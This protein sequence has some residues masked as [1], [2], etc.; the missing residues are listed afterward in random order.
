MGWIVWQIQN[1]S[2]PTGENF[3]GMTFSGGTAFAPS[4]RAAT[5]VGKLSKTYAAFSGAAGDT[6]LTLTGG[7][8][9]API[10]GVYAPAIGLTTNDI[11][12]GNCFFGFSGMSGSAVPGSGNGTY[13]S[14]A[15]DWTMYFGT[16]VPNPPPT[17]PSGT[18]VNP[19]A[20]NNP[21]KIVGI[22]QFQALTFTLLT[23][24]PTNS[25]TFVFSFAVGSPLRFADTGT[26]GKSIPGGAVGNPGNPYGP[27]SSGLI[28]IPTGT[29]LGPH[30]IDARAQSGSFNTYVIQSTL[31]VTGS[32]GG[33]FTEA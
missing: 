27:V 26:T 30:I 5:F 17:S 7:A 2:L 1:A 6:L 21:G 15:L 23:P 13:D 16:D 25:I 22:Q 29:P 19:A 9:Y 11:I 3:N 20:N 10:P 14:G 24:R 31:L 32:S 12:A 8:A 28:N 4:G 18:L 33:G